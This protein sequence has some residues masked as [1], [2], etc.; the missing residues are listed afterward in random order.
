MRAQAVPTVLSA[1]L[2]HNPTYA[3][4]QTLP[5][6]DDAEMTADYLYARQLQEKLDRGE[7]L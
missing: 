5:P 7:D 1:N 3:L 2:V 4:P 6:H